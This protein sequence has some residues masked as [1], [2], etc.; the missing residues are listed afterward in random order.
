MCSGTDSTMTTYLKYFVLI[1]LTSSLSKVNSARISTCCQQNATFNFEKRH[2]DESKSKDVQQLK[3]VFSNQGEVQLG[4]I[5]L[6]C[7]HGMT[8]YAIPKSDFHVYSDSIQV[9]RF[10]STQKLQQIIKK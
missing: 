2:C 4:H 8:D 3:E 5:N 10:I 1:C 6:F 9:S 7:E